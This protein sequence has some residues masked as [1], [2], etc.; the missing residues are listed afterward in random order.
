MPS[1]TVHYFTPT[2]CCPRT[3]EKVGL[4]TTGSVP[5]RAG[6]GEKHEIYGT[7]KATLLASV[8]LGVFTSTLPVV[9]PFG[10]VVVISVLETTLNVAAV[11]LKVTL[12]ASVRSFPR[13]VTAVPTAPEVGRVITNGP[14][15][16]LRLKTVPQPLLPQASLAPPSGVVP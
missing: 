11:P 7:R 12:L 4:K 8:R 1:E 14:S 10:T 2:M 5:A 3:I 13:I 6:R 9:A 15:P 16:T